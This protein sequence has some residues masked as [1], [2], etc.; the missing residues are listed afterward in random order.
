VAEDRNQTVKKQL[1]KKRDEAARKKIP[2][3]PGEMVDDA[4]AR[5]MAGAGRWL[6]KNFGALQWVIVAAIAAGIG[7]AIYDRHM[8]KRAEQASA[9][10]MKGTL[11]ERGRISG[12]ASPPKPEEDSVED[13]TPVFKSSEERR[14]TALASYHKVVSS[15]PGTGAAILARM[16]EAGILFDKRDWEGA[17][18][19]YRDVKDSALAKA[20]VSVRGRAI[21]GM[22]LASESKGDIDGALKSFRELENTDVR[23]LKELGMYHQARILFA[24]GDVDKAKELLKSARE[25]IKG[26]TSGNPASA[27]GESHPFAFLESQID[28]LLRRI[29]PT[30]VPAS[31]PPPMPGMPGMAGMPPGMGDPRKMT[32]EQLQLLQEQL[33]RSMQ[34]MKNKPPIPAPAGSQ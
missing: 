2:L 25:K 26:S 19:A 29:D 7:Y 27:A 32:P 30:A 1:L 18:S 23:G 21:E 8:D 31:S 24:K 12:A 14:E 3:A 22:G 20:D 10:L 15:Y 34:D 5:G 13:P 33:K 9:E 4:L 6:K 28:D 17:L 11:S 16:G